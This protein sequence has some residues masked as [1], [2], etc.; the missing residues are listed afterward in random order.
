MI[1]AIGGTNFVSSYV[2]AIHFVKNGKEMVQAGYDK[3]SSSIPLSF[4]L[5]N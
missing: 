5:I 4:E 1:P 2:N 3:V